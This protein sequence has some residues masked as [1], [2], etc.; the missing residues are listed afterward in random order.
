MVLWIKGWEMRGGDSRIL[1]FECAKAASVFQV[2]R[3]PGVFVDGGHFVHGTDGSSGAAVLLLRVTFIALRDNRIRTTA[4]DGIKNGL[5]SPQ[6]I[7]RG[8]MWER[9][10][11][12]TIQ[13]WRKPIHAM[14]EY[15]VIINA[16]KESQNFRRRHRHLPQAIAATA[17]YCFRQHRS[18]WLLRLPC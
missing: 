11:A 18:S 9:N 17:L 7:W 1:A 16:N 13:Y 15:L 10:N 5:K 2:E 6:N 3:V 12:H 14:L 4:H 8:M